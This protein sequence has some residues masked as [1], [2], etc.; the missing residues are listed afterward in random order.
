MLFRLFCLL[1]SPLLLATAQSELTG[2]S[3]GCGNVS[4]SCGAELLLVV[5]RVNYIHG[6]ECEDTASRASNFAAALLAKEEEL[7]EIWDSV[8]SSCAGYSKESC[9]YNMQTRLPHFRGGRLEVQYTCAAGIYS[10]CGGQ[11][12]AGSGGYIS[13]PG[14]PKYYL[15]GGPCVWNISGGPGQQI[16]VTVLDTNFSTEDCIEIKEEGAVRLRECGKLVEIKRV[17]STAH[18]IQISTMNSEGSASR[19]QSKR[20]ML[21]RYRTIGCAAPSRIADGEVVFANGTLAQLACNEGHVFKSTLLSRRTLHCRG[22]KWVERLE[23]CVSLDFLLQYGSEDIKSSLQYSH[24][25]LVQEDSDPEWQLEVGATVMVGI[26][27]LVS[28]AIAIVLYLKYSE[29][30]TYRVQDDQISLKEVQTGN[31]NE[32]LQK[33]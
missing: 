30:G 26:L 24:S 19:L 14:Y 20:G 6:T 7:V 4:L 32:K 27:L 23:H 16:E 29:S 22:N 21:L 13:S 28:L 8:L 33:Y 31:E 18:N 11:I 17:L 15:G 12:Q 5:E 25:Q 9:N 1:A 3:F 10:Y 2:L